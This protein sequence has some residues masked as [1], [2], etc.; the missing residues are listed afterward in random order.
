MATLA[1]L[2][3][4]LQCFHAYGQIWQLQAILWRKC[5][6]LSYL[7]TYMY[8]L[9]NFRTASVFCHGV[10]VSFHK[11]QGNISEISHHSI[12]QNRTIFWSN[13]FLWRWQIFTA[14]V[15]IVGTVP[16]SFLLH[17]I[18]HVTYWDKSLQ[19]LALADLE[20]GTYIFCLSLQLCVHVSQLYGCS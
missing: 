3:L 16:Y 10:P 9:S 8:V 4:T 13:I 14:T 7:G 19:I 6:T 5:A 2:W 15:A 11:T 20:Q 17:E 12:A 1:K 18:S